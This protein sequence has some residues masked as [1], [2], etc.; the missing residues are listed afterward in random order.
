MCG[1]FG[2]LL[3]KNNSK[4]KLFLDKG[5]KDLKSRGPDFNDFFTTNHKDYEVAIA[6]TR[7][8]IIDISKNN[9]QPMVDHPN[10]LILTYNGEIYNYLELKNELQNLGHKFK[11][12]GD[13][14]VL[15][16]AWVEWGEK[17]LHRLNGMFAFGI[18]NTKNGDLWLVR[19][20]FGVKPLFWNIKDKNQLL[21]SSSA[22]SISEMINSEI[23]FSYCSR[24]LQYKVF[25]T[26][27][28]ESPYKAVNSVPAGGVVKFNF[29][30]EQIE[31]NEFN[32]Y[33][34]SY[35][36]EKKE[37]FLMNFSDNEI[38]NY[39]FELINDATKIRLRSDVPIATSLS[40]GIDSALITSLASSNINKIKS[41]NYG[42]PTNKLSEGP[43]VSDLVNFLK[44]ENNYI[45]PELNKKYMSEL[46]CKTLHCQEAPF[47][48]TTTLAQNN[49]YQNIFEKGYKVVLGGQGGDEILAG[50]RK[51]FI[52]S[53]MEAFNNR[54]Y[55]SAL[56]NILSTF[57]MFF[58]EFNNMHLYL[59]NLNRYSGKKYYNFKIFNWELENINL[60]ANST[61]LKKR[62]IDD[63]YKWSLPSILRTEDRN[64]MGY[65]IES[66]LPFMDYRL[67]ELCIALPTRLKI[68]NGYNKWI[69]R[70][71]SKGLVTE[72]IR[73]SRFKRGFDVF[74]D[75][76]SNGLGETIRERILDNKFKLQP[77]I[78]ENI[79]IENII[80]DKN[81]EQDHRLLDECF[82]LTWLCR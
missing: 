61:S 53:I 34:L 30:Y 11:T 19:D 80:S 49:V 38:I 6:H 48:G 65:S 32:W 78:K 39:F 79:S 9:N 46:L 74:Q 36:V 70:K 5:I 18:Y 60:M 75:W 29:R 45:L 72:T 15:L 64:S 58:Y 35:N 28:S 8:S 40:G 59:S 82:M 26:P 66:R 13:T 1:I 63:I 57:I 56:K 23:D 27:L 7:L 17:C 68:K 54:E 81:L 33:K 50:Y 21:F 25:E 52:V 37:H 67:V 44:I 62:Q 47:S 24:G 2:F 20:R 12:Y 76:V 31:H 71:A 77:F 22:K 73:K 41:F 4:K 10:N 16:K 69:M 3:K 51:F 43:I 14:E 42:S 55:F